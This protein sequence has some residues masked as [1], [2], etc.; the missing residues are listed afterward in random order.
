MLSANFTPSF[1]SET[2]QAFGFE[3]V[4]FFISW[5]FVACQSRRCDKW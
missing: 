2:K 1:V 3:L 4:L 5:A